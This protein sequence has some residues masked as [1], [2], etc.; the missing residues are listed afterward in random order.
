[1]SEATIRNAACRLVLFIVLLVTPQMAPAVAAEVQRV[2]SPGG[3]EAWLIED[4]MVPVLSLR[5]AFRG[6]AALDPEG[7]A[8]TANM[9]ASLIDEGAGDLDSEAF[10]KRLADLSISLGFSAGRD[11]VEGRLGTL[12]E[13]RDEAFRLLALALTEAR[14]DAEPVQRVR[15]QIATSLARRAVD[16]GWIASRT[17]MELVF[18]GHPYARSVDGTPESVA[19]ITADDLRAFVKTRLARD[20]LIVGVAGD[21]TAAELAPLLDKAFGALPKTAGAVDVPAATLRNGGETVVIER[22]VP[23]SVALFG[24]AGIPRKDPDWYAGQVVNYVLGGGG[25]NSRLMEEIREKRGLAYGVSTGISPYD[26]ASVMIGQVATQNARVAESLDLVRQEWKRMAEEGPTQEEL[27]DA[28]TYLIG[29]FPIGLDSTGS[30]A[31]TLVAMQRYDLGID[32][33]DRRS[34]LIEAVT[35]EDARR[36]A[37]R[38]L[39]P[40]ALTFVVVGQPEG[41]KPT[42]QPPD[43]S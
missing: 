30:I 26:K 14:F 6:G 29:S 22:P 24:E 32:H 38:L 1:M 39:D 34:A 13:N 25:F 12:T 4:H 2:V 18:A 8:G 31:A 37:K 15:D 23:Q 17:F 9:A 16:P 28:K 40:A 7:K 33:L 27:D 43:A 10:Q 41:V 35:L 42:R 19:E 21:I 36:V 11:S 5:M 20:N 3:V